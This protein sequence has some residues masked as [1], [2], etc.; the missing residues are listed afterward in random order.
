HYKLTAEQAERAKTILTQQKKDTVHFLTSKPIGT[1]VQRKHLSYLREATVPEII[2]AYEK[3]EDE[4]RTMETT[5]LP[6]SSAND[7]ARYKETKADIARIR[8]EL[9]SALSQRTTLMKT[10]LKDVL[11]DA[12]P[13]QKEL[14][15]VPEPLRKPI[16]DYTMLDWSDAIVAWGTLAVGVLLLA[17]LFTRT[18]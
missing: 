10:A 12:K 8:N 2:A 11:K 3:L 14:L 17:G 4:L 7:L 5:V 1:K 13:E 9:K 15:P 18:A 16:S 6:T